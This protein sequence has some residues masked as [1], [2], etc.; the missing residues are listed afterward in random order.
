MLR[1]TISLFLGLALATE[2]TSSAAQALEPSPLCNPRAYGAKG[3]GVAKDTAAIQAGID[4][5]AAKGGGT[6]RL[7]AGIYLSAPIALK[8]NIT[9]QLDKGAILLGSADHGDYPPKTEFREPG[10]QSLVSATNA[11]HVAIT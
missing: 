3:D 4:A 9:L 11:S 7:T 2:F 6:V 1:H 5:C 10:L 8:S